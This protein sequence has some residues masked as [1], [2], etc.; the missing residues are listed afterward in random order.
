MNTNFKMI[1]AASMAV[2][3][4]CCGSKGSKIDPQRVA[5]RNVEYDQYF[6]EI[7]AD[8]APA[9]PDEKGF[10]RRWTIIEPI[11]KPNSGNTVFTDSYILAELT[12][13]YFK[14]QFTSD[15]KSLPK[16]GDQVIVESEAPRA[17]GRG[18][19]GGFGGGAPQGAGAPGAGQAR[20]QGAPG[21]G[22]PG[23]GQ[24]RPQ[25]APG[26]GAPGAG[27]ARPQGAPQ[28]APQ[29]GAPMGMGGFGGMMGGG[30]PAAAAA[31]Q[32]VKDTLT[33]HSVDSK[34]YNIKLIR[35]A[36]G[37]SEGQK[38][39]GLIFNAFTVINCEKDM[40]VRLAAGSNSASIWWVNGEKVLTLQADR[41]MVAD[42]GMSKRITLKKG[43][44]LVRAAVINGPGMSDMCMRFYNEDGSIVKN[45]TITNN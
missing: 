10:I 17:G 29:G 4:V 19:F 35:F 24:A 5:N 22:A 18:G 40:V 6:T 20:P 12:K 27:Q 34:L 3:L 38:R 45:I 21:A 37:T 31:P 32:M 7:K 13:E 30:A 2:A 25:G 42:D 14:G 8:A 26:A 11:N 36:L 44:N 43:K 1:L 28:G 41:R 15:I 33:W 16:T 39:Y 23:A 9:K